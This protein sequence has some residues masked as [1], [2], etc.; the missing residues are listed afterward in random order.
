V[1][2]PEVIDPVALNDFQTRLREWVLVPG[3]PAY[4][5]ARRVWNGSI[6]RHPAVIARCSGAA[7][8]MHAVRFG[9][10]HGLLLAVR[11]GGHG[12]AGPA[13]CDG[14]LV[15]DLS[16]MKGIRVDPVRRVAMVQPGCVWGDLDHESQAFGMAVP[17]GIISTTG[18]AGFTLGG[19][20]G[21]I[22]RRYGLACDNLL[23]C[24]VVT[25]A[26]D[27]V[28][29]GPDDHPDLFW[30]LR[31]GGG[32]FGVVTS[33]EFR[34]NPVGPMVL[35]GPIFHP[36]DVAGDVLRFARD[37]AEQ[38][39]DKV[40]LVPILR[41]APPA[42]FIPPVW[43]GRPVVSLA[44][45]FTGPVEEGERILGPVRRFGKPIADLLQP[46]PYVQ[47]Q[48]M[49]DAA[50]AAGWQNYWKTR[51]TDGLPDGAI[52]VLVAALDKIPTVYSDI[53]IPYLRGAIG[54]VPEEETAFG[55]R[56]TSWIVNINT[57]WEEP[58]GS[59]DHIA[60]TRA[61]WQ[62]LE[63]WAAPGVYVN[64]LDD[65]GEGRAREAY[66]PGVLRRLVAV[67]GR[68][69]PDNVFRLNQNIKP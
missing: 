60:W 35:A 3:T 5:A 24:D 11:G 26:G 68:W 39:P 36:G 44:C 25:A 59:D 4:E 31:G 50:W 13:V 38:A 69:D 15:V 63:P 57:R 67:K 28:H 42:P 40:V 10:E 56:L 12:V 7:D 52:D 62:Q 41:K 6:D 37:F 23:S 19:G 54:R 21:W 30:A 20:F 18:V 49:L 64:F 58:G 1:R 22:S 43:Q 32:N 46:R 14:G 51:N 8:V 55:H 29:A 27:L 9:R 45:C 16:P 65:E 66:A 2:V 53:K 34:L 33:F 48:G 61:L 47:L 17:G